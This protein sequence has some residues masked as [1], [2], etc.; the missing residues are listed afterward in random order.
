M[1][2][3]TSIS[4]PSSSTNLS[5]NTSND[6]SSSCSQSPRPCP[7]EGSVVLITGA[8][9]GI[10]RA[11]VAGF[12][13]AKASKVY[14]AVRDVSSISP[15]WIQS[16][17]GTDRIFPLYVDLLKP[18]TIYDAAR[19][20]ATDVDILVCNAGILRLTDQTPLEGPRAI[21]VLDEQFRVN[22]L[23]LQH[24]AQAFWPVLQQPPTTP[25]RPTALVQINSTSSLRCSGPRFAGYAASKA[26]AYSL[27]QALRASSPHALVLSVHP[28]P[29][30]T[31]MVDQFGGRNRSESPEQ[32]CAA[33]LEA[34]E[35]GGNS[36]GPSGFHVYTDTFSRY[37]GKEYENFATKVIEETSKY[38]PPPSPP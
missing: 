19:D 20:V 34:L 32:V 28:G 15:D 9:R 4:E 1:T 23:G 8:N 3:S 38:V 7:V 6:P 17:G 18:D 10:G 16:V 27:T 14:A 33:I 22:V 5:N 21:E 37:I 25:R 29:I 2:T 36:S 12:L 11:L 30:A 35:A 13:E 26:A 31:D 24:L